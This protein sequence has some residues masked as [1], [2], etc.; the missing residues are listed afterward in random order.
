MVT[1]HGRT[2]LDELLSGI[3]GYMRVRTGDREDAYALVT[4][5]LL[6]FAMLS[7]VILGILQL[8]YQAESSVALAERKSRAASLAQQQMDRVLARDFD[9]VVSFEG[10]YRAVHLTSRGQQISTNFLYRVETAQPDLQ[11]RVKTIDV[12]VEWG[13]TPTHHLTLNSLKGDAW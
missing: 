5:T 11:R 7:V 12:R 8:F 10:N 9:D 4:E 6:G 2:V 3:L 13:S 1:T